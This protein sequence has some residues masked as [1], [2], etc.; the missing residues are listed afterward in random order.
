MGCWP[1]SR[2]Y[3]LPPF[4]STP[5][6]PFKASP[7]QGLRR[8][9]LAQERS[10]K[11]CPLPSRPLLPMILPPYLPQPL[12]R[13]RSQ[14]RGSPLCLLPG[15]Q[16]SPCPTCT[17][18]WGDGGHSPMVPPCFPTDLSQA[19]P[20]PATGTGHCHG[21]SPHASLVS[22]ALPAPAAPRHRAL[23]RS[24]EEHASV[25]S[26]RVRG[27]RRGWDGMWVHG[28]A[29]RPDLSAHHF[30]PITTRRNVS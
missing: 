19:L 10:H 16:T 5:I 22:P 13:W 2:Q 12:G 30:T 23:P 29:R 4:R 15:P 18:L 20:A 21:P 28:R 26:C 14:Y 1:L 24:L 27:G 17:S 3:H 7:S 9:N 8:S 6:Q 25:A 11:E